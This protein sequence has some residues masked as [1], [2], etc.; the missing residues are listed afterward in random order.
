M[1]LDTPDASPV[2]SLRGLLGALE[3]A[4]LF[5]AAMVGFI[6]GCVFLARVLRTDQD[7]V[8]AIALGLLLAVL[9]LARPWWF[10]SHPKALFL[11][12]AIGDLPTTIVYL[13]VAAGL[14]VLGAVRVHR[15]TLAKAECSALLAGS[16]DGHTR[17]RLLRAE[18]SL[19]IPG[20]GS[21][22]KHYTCGTFEEAAK[23]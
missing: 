11:R 13:A 12:A 18:P 17:L 7:A 19:S 21:S 9:T 2:L 6:A 8:F 5:I 14:V 3:V 20:L 10:W 23:P 15:I 16:P 22:S 1:S 4:A